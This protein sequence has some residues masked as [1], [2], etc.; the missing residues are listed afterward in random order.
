MKNVKRPVCDEA[1]D[2]EV[3]MYEDGD[4]LT[5]PNCGAD[6]EISIDG[7]KVHLVPTEES[8]EVGSTD[9]ESDWEES[10][11]EY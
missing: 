7:S 2:V 9:F 6:L 8:E 10:G 1:F 11:E 5:C 4:V 3:D